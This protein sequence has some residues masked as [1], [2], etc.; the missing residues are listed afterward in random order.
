MRTYQW[1]P[2][3]NGTGSDGSGTWDADQFWASG[4]V[5]NL[6]AEGSD[7]V[8]GANQ[9]AAGMIT[10]N[11]VVSPNSI[12]FNPAGSVN[13]VITGGSINLPN[14]STSI[15]ANTNATISSSLVGSGGLSVAGS[16]T[17]TLTNGNAY[18]GNTTVSGGT[19]A[20]ATAPAGRLGRLPMC[21]AP[22]TSRSAAARS[23]ATVV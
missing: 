23:L 4:G 17:L 1:D 14:A 13:Y 10:I 9:G 18:T 8:I 20:F 21:P 6:W 5:D 11:N 22:A 15:T 12:T 2:V 3:Q 7:A 19:L 16:G